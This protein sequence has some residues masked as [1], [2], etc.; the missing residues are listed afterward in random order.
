[1]QNERPDPVSSSKFGVEFGEL[2]FIVVGT[3]PDQDGPANFKY[4]L[5]VAETIATYM[6][7]PKAIIEKS[8]ITVA[9][10]IKPA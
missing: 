6:Q 2:Q 4:V 10:P 8:T 1:L 9:L 7:S 3:P 5:K